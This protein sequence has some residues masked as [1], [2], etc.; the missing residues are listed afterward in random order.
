MVAYDASDFT[1]AEPLLHQ[2]TLNAYEQVLILFVI[3]VAAITLL[4]LLATLAGLLWQLR[5]PATTRPEKLSTTANSAI[6]NLS[7]ITRRLTMKR[8]ALLITTLFLLTFA[9]QAQDRAATEG[10]VWGIT[11]FRFKPNKRADYM[12]FVRE[13]RVPV[14]MEWKRQGLIVDYKFYFNPTSI[15]PQ[16]P[17][18]VEAVLYRNFGEMLDGDEARGKKF[19]DI[20]LKH[21][22]S[23]ENRR[24]VFEELPSLREILR[25]Y[26]LREMTIHPLKAAGQ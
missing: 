1:D 10:P 26:I 14:L 6:H 4:A 24:K 7:L 22:G 2:A 21:Y 13:H 5:R 11:E 20:T 9:A 12:K 16:E 17:E 19:Q 15:G 3:V 25:R 8:L 23:E 18:L